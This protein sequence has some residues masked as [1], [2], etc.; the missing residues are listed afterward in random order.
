[1][2]HGILKVFTVFFR[3]LAEY[4]SLGWSLAGRRAGVDL[5]VS[6]EG[7]AYLILHII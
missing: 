5:P 6:I 7:K 4:H 1:M 2:E 3:S